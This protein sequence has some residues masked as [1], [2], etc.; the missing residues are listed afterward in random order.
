MPDRSNLI[1]SIR[2][3]NREFRKLEEKHK[4]YEARLD[5]LMKHIYLTPKQEML[6]QE[7]KKQKLWTK[8]KMAE[9]VQGFLSMDNQ[10]G[11]GSSF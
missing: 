3:Q 8:D 11:D 4:E 10:N 2:Q 6:K 1:D 7:I 9:I 5:E